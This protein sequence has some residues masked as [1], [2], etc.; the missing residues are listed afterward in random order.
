MVEKNVRED[1]ILLDSI[2]YVADTIID[3]ESGLFYRFT[4]GEGTF[5]F[6]TDEPMLN[7]MTEHLA[8]TLNGN[9]DFVWHR[10]AVIN[11]AHLESAE[12][13]HVVENETLLIFH[14]K[15]GHHFALRYAD[16]AL[17]TADLHQFKI[18]WEIGKLMRQR[19]PPPSTTAH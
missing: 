8:S 3:G 14:F 5:Y 15:D 16:C 7:A 9:A 17:A 11:I 1:H 19:N 2:L 12:E 10:N 18:E 13:R 4:T 6:A